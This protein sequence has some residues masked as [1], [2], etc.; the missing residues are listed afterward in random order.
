MALP[1][2]RIGSLEV[3][4][5]IVGGNPFSGISHQSVERNDEMADYYT[6]A[7]IKE[8]LADCE[9]CGI[10]TFIGRADNHIA[11]LIREYRNEGGAIQWIAQSAPERKDIV[12]NLQ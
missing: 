9:R 8:T 7:K 10:N 3:S 6:T 2:I 12:H 5:L 11:R 1:R 4:K